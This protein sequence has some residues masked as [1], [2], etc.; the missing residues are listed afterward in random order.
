MAYTADMETCETKLMKNVTAIGNH[1]HY[2]VCG[3]IT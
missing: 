2:D 3:E 1:I